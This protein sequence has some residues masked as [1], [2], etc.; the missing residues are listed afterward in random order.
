MQL[1]NPHRFVCGVSFDCS[2]EVLQCVVTLC[3]LVYVCVLQCCAAVTVK[4]S[5]S[6]FVKSVRS[7]TAATRSSKCGPS[8]CMFFAVLCVREQSLKVLIT[9]C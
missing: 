6:V 7:V 4:S 1:C 3:R 8:V 2:Y 9:C 5:Q